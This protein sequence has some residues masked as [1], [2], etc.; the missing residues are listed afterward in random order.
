MHHLCITKF[1]THIVSEHLQLAKS[2][3]VAWVAYMQNQNT[4]SGHRYIIYGLVYQQSL[5]D[6]NVKLWLGW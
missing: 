6:G 3:V 4:V 2:L 1:A 5:T